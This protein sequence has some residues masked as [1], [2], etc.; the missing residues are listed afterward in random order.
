ML[1]AVR[2]LLDSGDL[3]GSRQDETFNLSL[4]PLAMRALR[5]PY[6]EL[7]MASFDDEAML[8]MA[9]HRHQGG[10]ISDARQRA[11]DHARHAPA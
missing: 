7:H 11:T 3:V 1:D 9:R 10:R 8:F 5:E 6:G 4:N 2:E